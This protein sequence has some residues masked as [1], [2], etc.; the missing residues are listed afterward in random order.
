MGEEAEHFHS[1][2]HQVRGIPPL[3]ESLSELYLAI[4]NS[5]TCHSSRRKNTSTLRVITPHWE[6]ACSTS[7]S[8][9]RENTPTLRVITLREERILPLYEAL[10]ENGEYFHPTSHYSPRRGNTSTLPVVI[11]REGR[12]LRLYESLESLFG[13]GE[14]F[15]STSH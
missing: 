8:S 15:H 7:Y 14:Y 5:S 12:I 11:L 1:T 4:N 6:Y 3:Y 2:G 10:T 9:R 13:L